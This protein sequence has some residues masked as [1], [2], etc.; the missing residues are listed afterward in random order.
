MYI[1]YYVTHA[2]SSVVVWFKEIHTPLS[3]HWRLNFKGNTN[4]KL[5]KT[6]HLMVVKENFNVL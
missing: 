6:K 1:V 4:F 5:K 2:T 3:C